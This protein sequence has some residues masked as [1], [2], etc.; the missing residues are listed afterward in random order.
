MSHRV[1]KLLTNDDGDKYPNTYWHFVEK[2]GDAP[3]TLCGG[4]CFGDGET[5]LLFKEKV[6]E[7]GGV[8]C[9]ICLSIIKYY[10]SINL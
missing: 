1:V 10:K 8:T 7:K 2:R 4:E 6:V 5:S 3:R 9:P